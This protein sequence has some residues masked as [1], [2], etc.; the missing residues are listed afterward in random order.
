MKMEMNRVTLYV[1]TYNEECLTSVH[2]YMSYISWIHN[3]VKV[4]RWCGTEHKNTNIQYPKTLYIF[5]TEYSNVNII[6]K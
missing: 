4:T 6:F 3:S 2:A 1:Q 5:H